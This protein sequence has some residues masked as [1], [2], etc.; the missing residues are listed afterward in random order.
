M[1]KQTITHL[2]SRFETGDTPTETDFSD[3]F[4]SYV[5]KD[6]INYTELTVS[7]SNT[8]LLSAD[9]LIV[10]IVFQDASSGT[11]KVGTTA[12]ASDIIDENIIGGTPLVEGLEYFVA[13]NTTIHFTG[14]FTAKIYIQ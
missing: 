8:Y 3:V 7:G 13:A 11:V 6:D 10:R 2:K 5:H 1:A 14:N 4:D 12:G 9:K